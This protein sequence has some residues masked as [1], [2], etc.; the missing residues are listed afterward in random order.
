[1]P[2]KLNAAPYLPARVASR[3]AVWGRVIRAQ[4]VA[5]KITARQFCPRAG[6]SESTLRRIEN[7]DPAASVAA[8]LLALSA[9]GVLDLIVPMPDARFAEGNPRARATPA[10]EQ[11]SDYF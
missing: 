3:L 9:L 1:M 7:G 10:T 11:T 5:Q 2:K 6:V 4:R 8:Y